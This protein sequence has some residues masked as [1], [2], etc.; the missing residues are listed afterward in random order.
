MTPLTPSRTVCLLSVRLVR[1]IRAVLQSHHL[2]TSPVSLIPAGQAPLLSEDK[3]CHSQSLLDE[4]PL[5]PWLP[6]MTLPWKQL[7]LLSIIDN[8]AGRLSR[9][10]PVLLS[11]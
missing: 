5:R 3:E 10:F 7:L 9:F 1:E 8:L 11:F 6:K 2:L 4:I